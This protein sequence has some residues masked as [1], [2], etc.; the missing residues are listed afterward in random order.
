MLIFSELNLDA[1]FQVHWGRNP[2]KAL[3]PKA[4][5][6]NWFVSL[7]MW[8]TLLWWVNSNTHSKPPNPD[9][10]Y[11]PI[12]SF[13]PQSLTYSSQV[14]DFINKAEACLP[15]GKRLLCSWLLSNRNQYWN[16]FFWHQPSAF[17]F[18]SYFLILIFHTAEFP[19]LLA[20][21]ISFVKKKLLFL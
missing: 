8:S 4:A 16:S 14:P 10:I 13:A 6:T 21:F 19:N 3:Y 12:R 17:C 9:T 18:V 7:Q 5:F 11:E 2:I 20:W 15:P 1:S